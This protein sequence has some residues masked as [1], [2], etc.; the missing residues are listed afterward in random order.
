MFPCEIMKFRLSLLRYFLPKTWAR[1][2]EPTPSAPI[3]KPALVKPLLFVTRPSP[4]S[5][6]P[7][8][9]LAVP[10]LENMLNL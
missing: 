1:S 5:A 8:R 9:T 3:F 6:A 2:F 4:V 10:S 7:P